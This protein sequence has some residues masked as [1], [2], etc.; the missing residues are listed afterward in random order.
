MNENTWAFWGTAEGQERQ[1]RAP[2]EIFMYVCKMYCSAVGIEQPRH[3]NERYID[4]QNSWPCSFFS[5]FLFFQN[6]NTRAKANALQLT[7]LLRSFPVVG[8]VS[9]PP[10]H[11]P[12][13][14]HH[15]KT[16]NT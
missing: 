1:E 8:I 7:L 9:F 3:R 2:P 15:S 16:K 12:P 11:P 6:W 4:E 5:F 14:P 10:L 13:G